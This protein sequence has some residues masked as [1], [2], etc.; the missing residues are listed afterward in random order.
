MAINVDIFL[1][2]VPS[3]TNRNDVRLYDPTTPDGGALNASLVATLGA[4]TI[5]TAAVLP[6]AASLSTTFGSMTL[7]GA[8]VEPVSATAAI[9]LANLTL[10]GAAVEPIVATL[11]ATLA[12]LTLTGT[13]TI[14]FVALNASLTVTFSGLT[15]SATVQTI[16]T[17][18][19]VDQ[20]KLLPPRLQYKFVNDDGRL[21]NYNLQLM[22]LM[23]DAAMGRPSGTYTSFHLGGARITTG[24]GTPEG[25]V[26]GSP[27]DLYFRRDGGASTCLYVKQSGTST[28]AGWVAK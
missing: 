6:I 13:A 14:P 4:L 22:Q 2:S 19:V 26:S 10:T 8:A 3:D 12:D 23:A 24:T 1:R 11:A 17:P 20:L 15:L 16:A 25:A 27:G 7:T 18:G 9:T 28:T 21:N 5:A